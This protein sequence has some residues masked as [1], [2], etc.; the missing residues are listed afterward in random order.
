MVSQGCLCDDAARTIRQITNDRAKGHEIDTSPDLP[1]RKIATRDLEIGANYPCHPGISS[2]SIARTKVSAPPTLTCR[3]WSSFETMSCR[4]AGSLRHFIASP[5]VRLRNEVCV[6]RPFAR[7]KVSAPPTL[8]P[9]F[10]CS[11][12]RA[13]KRELPLPPPRCVL[14]H[15]HR[16]TGDE[17]FLVG[18]DDI[19]LESG[20]VC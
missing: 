18:G 7:T 6:T 17:Q 10:P 16:V 12:T 8:L 4:D 13:A 5:K 19:R 20:V 3:G 15:P 1:V 11:V 2:L 14:D 9:S